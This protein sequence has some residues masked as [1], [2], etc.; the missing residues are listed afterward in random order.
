MLV[1]D[2]PAVL[3]GGKASVK[4]PFKAIRFS[5]AALFAVIGTAVLLRIG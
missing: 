5:A 2:I 3:L 4:I 1:A